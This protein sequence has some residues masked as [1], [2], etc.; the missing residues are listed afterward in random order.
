M[1]G[2]RAGRWGIALGQELRQRG[3]TLGPN[4]D[5]GA[6]DLAAGLVVD[7]F[8]T[9]A[10]RVAQAV[11][12]RGHDSL[13]ACQFGSGFCRVTPGVPLQRDEQPDHLLLAHLHRPP[14]AA[15][16]RAARCDELTPTGHEAGGW[17]PERLTSE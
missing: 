8:H 3:G 17:A 2:G 9:H 5:G 13:L 1:H 15:L 4:V 16:M 6:H 14:D 10:R 12:N 11:G 7:D